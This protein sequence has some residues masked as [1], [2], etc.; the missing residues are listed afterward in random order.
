MR[1]YPDETGEHVTLAKFHMKTGDH[2]AAIA[3]LSNLMRLLGSSPNLHKQRGIA[4]QMAGEDE[5]AVADLTLA[6]EADAND[7]AALEMRGV[8]HG[9]MGQRDRA[10][11][12][13]KRLLALAPDNTKI[14]A[15]I[16]RLE[17]KP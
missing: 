7:L 5:A 1:E 12:D 6:L 14:G 15:L 10:I 16:A 11:A 3:D 9:N 2:R 8:A 4:Y 17:A 13:F